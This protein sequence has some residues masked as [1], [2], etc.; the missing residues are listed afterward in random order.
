MECTLI[1]K[2]VFKLKLHFENVRKK[3]NN[4]KGNVDLSI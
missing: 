4:G 3:K 1:I 2:D